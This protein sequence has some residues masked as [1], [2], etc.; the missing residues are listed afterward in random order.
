M[1]G[2][3]LFLLVLAIIVLLLFTNNWSLTKVNIL[4]T[5][6]LEPNEIEEISNDAKIVPALDFSSVR[7]D[8]EIYEPGD[9]VTVHITIANN[10]L[11]SYTLTV[12]WI[13]NDTRTEGWTNHSSES[14]NI[15]Q[16]EETYDSWIVPYSKGE[17][18]AH[19][20]IK[21]DNTTIAPSDYVTTFRVV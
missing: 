15:S 13:L 8:Q 3:W 1:K 11:T 7:L 20:R 9:N 17:W 12:D 6:E 2:N 21:P 14:Y 18:E 10:I 16:P 19:L 5:F 4:G